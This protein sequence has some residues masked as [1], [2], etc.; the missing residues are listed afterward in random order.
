MNA[1]KGPALA[2]KVALVTGGARNIGRAISLDLAAHG[3]RVAV[4]TRRSVEDG[5]SVLKEIRNAGRAPR[6]GNQLIPFGRQGE[7]AEMATAVRFLCS[8]DSSFIT[9]QTIHVNGGQMMF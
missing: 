6:P 3:V 5:R 4:N 8:S 2:G 1:E 7:S 9:G